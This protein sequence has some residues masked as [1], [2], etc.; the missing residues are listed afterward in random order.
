MN[1]NNLSELS[2]LEKIN[3]ISENTPVLIFKHSTRCS[4]S[5]MAKRK[6]ESD[7]NFSV[8]EIKPFYLDLI[9]LRPISNAI[10]NQYKVTHQ[11]PQ[12]LL[13]KGGKCVFSASHHEISAEDI[14]LQK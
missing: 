10:A 2:D 8:E 12:V 5:S 1:W 14:G 9:A 7:W 3:E 4:V 13:I 11:S 6:L